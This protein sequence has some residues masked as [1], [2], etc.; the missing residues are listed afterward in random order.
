MNT[1][2]EGSTHSLPLGT[3]DVTRFTVALLVGVFKDNFVPSHH[4]LRTRGDTVWTVLQAGT[5]YTLICSLRR[6]MDGLVERQK[7]SKEKEMVQSQMEYNYIYCNAIRWQQH[8]QR[9]KRKSYRACACLLPC[10]HLTLR[11]TGH[12][13]P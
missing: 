2:S 6:R 1:R 5:R 11:V 12:T 13:L 4:T 8:T 7:Q 3:V 10:L 9:K